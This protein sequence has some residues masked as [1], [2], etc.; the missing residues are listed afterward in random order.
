MT[1]P[2]TDEE[3]F[4]V[5]AAYN[6]ALWPAAFA[7]WA[8]SLAAVLLFVRGGHRGHR[9]LCALLAAHWAWSAVAYHAAFFTRINPAGWLFAGLF[10]TQAWLFVWFGIVHGRLQFST[11]RSARHAVAALLVAYSFV[12]PILNLALG[13]EYP[14]IPLFAVPCP[15]TIF[16]AGLLLAAVRPPWSLLVVP[17][18]WS[19]IAMSATVLFDVRADFMLL[20]A[21]V[22]LVAFTIA[23]QTTRF[24]QR[25]VAHD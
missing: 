20:P 22:L 9:A 19:L 23:E 16:T 13:L 7:L 25:R 10:V 14:R 17:V 6:A 4:D 15:T 11:G 3:F 24:H 12:Y 21:A 18:V 1:L 5:L 2:F 8:V